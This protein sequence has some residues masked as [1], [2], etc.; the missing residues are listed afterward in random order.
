MTHRLP[1]GPIGTSCLT[2]KRRHKK[3]DRAKP[4]CNRCSKGGYECLGYGHTKSGHTGSDDEALPIRTIHSTPY[5]SE[6][7]VSSASTHSADSPGD[8]EPLISYDVLR[9]PGIYGSHVQT[10][11]LTPL[12][13]SRQL[14]DPLVPD[15]DAAAHDLPLTISETYVD[16]ARSS[17]HPQS[18]SPS[19]LL[20][21]ALASQ[22]PQDVP[23][24]P[25]VRR[26]VDYVIS[27]VDRILNVTYFRPQGN[28]VARFRGQTTWRLSTCDFARRGMLVYAKIRESILEGSDS[29]NGGNFARWIGG[30]EQVLSTSLNQPLTSYEYRERHND[31]L[32]IFYAKIAVFDATT[33]YRLMCHLAPNF[34]Q[35]VYSDPVLWSPEH[36]PALVSISHLFSS[37]RY[38][39]ACYVL[40]DIMASMIYGVP[41]LAEYNTDIEPFH[42]ELHA[43]E[44]MNCVPGEFLIL[45]AKINICRDQGLLADNWQTIERRLVTWEPRLKFEPE[46][47]DSNRSVAW[48]A[49]Q[50]SWRQTLLIYL[51]LVLCGART[52]DPRIQLSVRQLFQL[53]GTIKRHDSAIANV[54]FFVQY[55]I[56]GVCSRTEKQRR[57]VRERLGCA[58][59]S[60]FWLFHGPDIIPVLDHLW[61]GAAIG[62]KPVTWDDYIRSRHVMLPLS[63]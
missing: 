45:L 34:L 37:P 42:T 44:W 54:H 38:G 55:L 18:T 2:C 5:P 58:A 31:I 12:N 59:E 47:L 20:L 3:C 48:L 27:C 11:S 28:Q 30:Y 51:Y 21:F 43:A 7:P 56:A 41:H 32:E 53:V 25:D 22:I 36:N 23:L 50:E 52:D 61:L 8:N 26:T 4:V 13:A 6:S 33:T 24:P 10:G 17:P 14:C 40:M 62:G 46:G 57:I 16:G 15:A 49:L 60:R 39:P 1:P 63:S 35:V 9:T 29:R 19:D